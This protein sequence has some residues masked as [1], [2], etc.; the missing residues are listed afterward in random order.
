MV[1]AGRVGAMQRDTR[2]DCGGATALPAADVQALV[3]VLFETYPLYEDRESRRAVERVL[4][5]L[6]A[7]PHGDAL[8]P[9]IV[10]GIK[11]ECLKKGMAHVNAFVLVDWCA[12]LLVEL[13]QSPQRW[14][15]YGLDVALANAR[16][17]ETCV[18]AAS[19]RRAGRIS[20]SALVS[21]RRALR[22]ILRSQAAAPDA[23]S[24][25]VTALTAKGSTPTAANA[26]FLGAIAGVSS[27]LPSVKP[28]L[29]KLKSDYYAF[30][31]REIVA[32]RSQLPDH[33]SNALFDFFTTFP[34]LEEVRKELIPP[35]EKA[36]LRAPEVVLNDII[37]PMILALP[38]SIDLSDVLLGNMLKPLLSNIK[39]TNPTIRAG[40]L[41]TFSAFASR[42]RSDQVI[43]KVAEE[44][45]IPLKQGKVAGADQ[46]VLHAQML[47][48]LPR[49]TSLS[50][51]IPNGIVSVALKEPSEPAVVAE[52]STMTDHLTFGLANGVALDKAVSD[53]FTKGM[54]DKR[55]PVR[56]LWAIRAADLWWNLSDAQHAQ[57]DIS[58]FCQATL[59]K[60][61][62]MW[63]EVIANPIPATQSGLVTVGHYVTALLLDKA[64]HMK[65]EKIAT[66]Y[67]KSDVLSQ[68]LTVQPKP[69]FLLNPKVYSKLTTEDEV[70]IALRA[71]TAVAPFLVQNASPKEACASWAHAF[72]F[73]IV[74]QGVSA[75]AK[76][77]AK[78]ALT[79]TYLQVSP[80][81]ISN[82]TLR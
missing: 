28:E 75:K 44:I 14:A 79:R 20:D 40:A 15:Q 77:A 33:I 36:L 37:S 54:T 60:L 41:R 17:L 24:R 35:I 66:I 13:A 21:T 57:A 47:S 61:M 27:R 50:H 16:V 31:V 43:D 51:K 42:S 12:V 7:G 32:S 80:S 68:S 48:A 8:L 55:V 23:L 78:Q 53:A 38:E 76:S 49:S 9:A 6:V 81:S 29:E 72:M 19:T 11:Q 56:R 70:V 45:L 59:P 67:K 74:A 34:T 10:D 30:Y 65:D 3:Q 1:S 52:V 4:Q 46:K 62:D 18:G 26:V 64:R 2:A 25:L 63:Q 73:P 58:A 5:A 71:L 69:S 39:S 82:S 22:A